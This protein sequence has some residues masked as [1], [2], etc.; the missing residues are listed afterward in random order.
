MKMPKIWEILERF[1]DL[2]RSHG[3]K[4]SE[5]D[6]WIEI[7]NE[8][9]NFL[10]TRNINP[11]SFRRIAA[12]RKCVVQEGLSYRVVEASYTA[13]LLSE[14]PPKTLVNAIFEN[15]DF[16]KRIALYNL[17]PVL[18]GKNLGFKLNYTG[19]PVFEEFEKFLRKELKVEL[20]PILNPEIDS[21]K[22]TITRL[23]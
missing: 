3:W 7:R 20:K 23:A 14:T 22:H 2:C 10:W 11:S 21:E 5:K 12:N 18:E 8:Y 19:S 13:C 4:S 16:S 15:P 17:S 9:H 6:D 1:K